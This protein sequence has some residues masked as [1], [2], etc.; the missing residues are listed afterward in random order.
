MKN[1]LK[2]VVRN[3]DGLV[4]GI[5]YKF[6]EAGGVDWRSLIPTQFLY[7]KDK[8]GETDIT[9]LQDKDLVIT[10]G[11]I[12]YLAKLRG[13]NNYFYSIHTA[14]EHYAAVCCT[15]EWK[16]NYET[17]DRVVTSEGVAGAS[18]DNTSS[19]GRNFLVEIAGNRAF[20]RAVREFL[21]ISIVSQ[22]ELGEKQEHNNALANPAPENP[23]AR[24]ENSLKEKNLDFEWL[25]KKLTESGEA[26]AATWNAVSDIPKEKLLNIIERVQKFKPRKA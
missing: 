23:Y 18:L 22:E 7:A 5:D 17:E 4:E 12:R 24:L 6:N 9:K 11:G 14:S 20:C 16:P 25:K 8:N 26:S 10:L 19:F 2:R 21:N 3:A 15:I 13:Y 1:T